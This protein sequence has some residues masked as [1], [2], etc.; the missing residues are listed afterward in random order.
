MISSLLAVAWIGQQVHNLFLTYLIGEC[1]CVSVHGGTA[2]NH[3]GCWSLAV[4]EL[5]LCWALKLIKL[6]VSTP[7]VNV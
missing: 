2:L 7:Q 6:I 4:E 1:M 5:V 3:T